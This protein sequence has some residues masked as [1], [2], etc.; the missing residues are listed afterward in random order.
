MD[1]GH[2]K[3]VTLPH[4]LSEAAFRKYESHIALAVESFPGPIKIVPKDYGLSQA[5]Y[6]ARFRDAKRSLAENRWS[7]SIPMEKFLDVHD[8]MVVVER[9]GFILIG[10]KEATRTALT[11]LAEPD[12]YV[13]ASATAEVVTVTTYQ[14]KLLMVVLASR[15]LLAAPAKVVG[16]SMD[17]VKY[18]ELNYDVTFEPTNDGHFILR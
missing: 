15:R 13:T 16:F 1:S 11:P 9:E 10:S 18:F 8:E 12:A 17:D 6:A 7:T 3:E 14:E 2:Q 5:T 4:R